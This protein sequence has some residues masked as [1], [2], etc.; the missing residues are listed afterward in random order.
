VKELGM[1]SSDDVVGKKK[2]EPR[3]QIVKI[4]FF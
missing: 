3:K 1:D 2:N 4:S